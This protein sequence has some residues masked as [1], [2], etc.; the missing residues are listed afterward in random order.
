MTTSIG[1]EG[2]QSPLDIVQEKLQAA[3]DPAQKRRYYEIVAM[4]MEK[5]A[6]RDPQSQQII[7][8]QRKGWFS[9][10]LEQFLLDTEVE[11]P[12]GPNIVELRARYR[13]AFRGAQGKG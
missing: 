2:L 10:A 12:Q 5:L 1:A 7:Q 3:E 8:D 13:P 6:E 11:R 9:K 4:I